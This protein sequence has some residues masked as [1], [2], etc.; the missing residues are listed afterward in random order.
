MRL[1]NNLIKGKEKNIQGIVTEFEYDEVLS[2]AMEL[3]T[4]HFDD[5]NDD[6][7]NFVVLNRINL[8]EEQAHD[9]DIV[10]G[11]VADDRINREINKYID[12]IIS[13]EKFLNDLIYYPSHQICF[14]TVQSLQVLSLSKGR[15]DIAMYDIDFDVILAMMKDYKITELEAADIYYASKI[16]KKLSDESTELYKKPWKEIYDMLKI[17]LKK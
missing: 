11:P 2:R 13:K 7:F 8:N 16:H 12:G 5:Y 14:C 1:Y 17:E 6:W 10:E 4:L 3:K 9:Y 15:T